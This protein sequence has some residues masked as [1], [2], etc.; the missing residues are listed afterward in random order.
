MEAGPEPSK[1][2]CASRDRGTWRLGPLLLSV[3]AAALTAGAL[4]VAFLAPAPSM[5]RFTDAEKV[6]WSAEL[7][8][9]YYD[10]ASAVL[11]GDGDPVEERFGGAWQLPEECGHIRGEED[12]GEAAREGLSEILALDERYES[13]RSIAA[14]TEDEAIL[15]LL[16]DSVGCEEARAL[17][18]R[19]LM[20]PREAFED[21]LRR[22]YGDAL[23]NDESRAVIAAE[24]KERG[25]E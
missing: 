6:E 18:E 21:Y 10:I 5:H 4:L 9:G 8:F 16:E 7:F 22:T 11:S 14:H 2:P 13:L 25:Y 12:A 15:A 3:A 19:P 20:G 1:A 23:D 24:L 17:R